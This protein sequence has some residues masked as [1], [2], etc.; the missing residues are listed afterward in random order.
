MF[1]VLALGADWAQL[2]DSKLL[3]NIS[4]AYSCLEDAMLANVIGSMMMWLCRRS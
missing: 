4:E 2:R 3:R 1:G